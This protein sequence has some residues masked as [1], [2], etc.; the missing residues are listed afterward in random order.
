[1]TAWEV[2]E[3]D[4]V[5]L[6]RALPAASIDAVVTDPPYG[7]RAASWDRPKDRR[8]H[9]E[10]IAA[11]HQ[12]LKPGAPL[13]TFASRRYL[14]VVMAALRVERGDTAECPIQTGVWI[15]RQG[16]TGGR[17]GTLRPE[18]EPW[19]ASGLL[20]VEEPDV[21]ALRAYTKHRDPVRR[22]SAARGFKPY[23]YT[24]NPDGPM[25]G[26]VFEGA[27]NGE[28]RTEHP[29]QK[30]LA[31]MRYLVL[32]ST[33]PGGLVLDPFC[34]SGTTGVAAVRH[35]RRFLGF[36]SVEGYVSIASERLLAESIEVP[37]CAR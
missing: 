14:D 16:F 9:A 30:P 27:R 17:V 11:A 21:R 28:E 24:P 37:E 6:L 35:G 34:G 18:H 7:E 5:E 31:I 26:T 3:G 20:R 22:K 33:P 15:H 32:L 25:A 1:M 19:I 36:D 12:A 2:R 8:W 4:A 23:T 29:T 13:M 10:W